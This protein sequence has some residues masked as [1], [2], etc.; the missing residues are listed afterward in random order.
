MNFFVCYFKLICLEIS[1][2][3]FKS[4]S[5]FTCMPWRFVNV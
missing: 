2:G 4:S 1:L 5:S 3:L